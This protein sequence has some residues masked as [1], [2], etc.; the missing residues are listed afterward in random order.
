MS[1]ESLEI[2]LRARFDVK[3]KM[4]L[5]VWPSQIHFFRIV[6]DLSPK[7]SSRVVIIAFENDAL[8]V[9]FI[10]KGN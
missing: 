9:K 5:S 1:L 6:V 4:C 10:T 8:S 7:K 3:H 2:A